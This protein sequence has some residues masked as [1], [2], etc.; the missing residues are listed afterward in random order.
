MLKTKLDLETI[1][2]YELSLANPKELQ[3]SN[4]LLKFIEHRCQTLEGLRTK[5]EQTRNG[6][7]H[8]YTNHI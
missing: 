3:A 7:Q 4:D 5:P 6:S 1:T 8:G 2:A